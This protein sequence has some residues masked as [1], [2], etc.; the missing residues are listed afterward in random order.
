MHYVEIVHI[1]QTQTSEDN[2]THLNWF[3]HDKI[4]HRKGQEKPSE[5]VLLVF[6]TVLQRK[7]IHF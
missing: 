4:H 7:A 3:I 2:K 5:N 6:L 1:L